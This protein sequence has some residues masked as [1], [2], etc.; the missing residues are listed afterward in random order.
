MLAVQMAS[1][2]MHDIDLRLINSF[3][4]IYDCGSMSRA[5][6]ILCCSPAAVSMRLKF[7]E[8]RLGRSLFIRHHHRLEPTDLG[9]KFYWKAVSL[10]ASYDDLIDILRV[11]GE[12]ET[13]RVGVPDDYALSFIQRG[14]RSIDVL[15]EGVEIDI[16]CDLSTNLNTAIQR[17]DID[18]GLATLDRLPQGG[19]LVSNLQLKWV[20]EPSVLPNLEER[21]P[22]AV[23]PEGC[24]FRRTMIEALEVRGTRWRVVSQSRTSS[25]VLAA[26]RSGLAI[27]SMAAGSIPEDLTVID[28][29]AL[30]DLK[31]IPVYL[32]KRGGKSS[33]ALDQIET[34]IIAQL[35][36]SQ[37]NSGKPDLASVA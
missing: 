16:V 32:L 13:I 26:V 18:I 37:R 30:P 17:Q 10:L 14:L 1:S 7:L 9:E 8:D 12:V 27:T 20:G 4:Q 19:Q 5:A 15:S 31:E 23:Y 35:H 28:H 2:R 29:P 11:R 22:L 33:Q 21:V 36:Q 25:G 34:A 6:E 24:V 3:V